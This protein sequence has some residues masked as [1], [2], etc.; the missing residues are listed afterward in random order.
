VTVTVLGATELTLAPI[1]E[2]AEL[3]G[4]AEEDG[5]AESEAQVALEEAAGKVP[6]AA[7]VDLFGQSVTVG[8]HE[9]MV[10]VSVIDMV[11]VTSA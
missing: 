6:F 1:S 10:A 5:A 2:A 3:H 7:A 11:E 4:A 9:V 8:A